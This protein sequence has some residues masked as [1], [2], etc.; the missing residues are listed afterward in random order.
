[1]TN[2]DR[3]SNRYLRSVSKKDYEI[4]C[5]EYIF[6]A[7]QG[8]PFGIAFCQKFNIIDMLL[9]HPYKEMS[10]AQE[11]IKTSGYINDSRSN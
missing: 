3:N 11:Y 2:R 4:F 5:K 6:D 7:I 10:K 8:V 1:M 9:F